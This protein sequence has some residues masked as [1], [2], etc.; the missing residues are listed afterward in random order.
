M[1]SFVLEVHGLCKKY[2]HQLVLNHFDMRVQ[3]GSIYGFVGENGAGKTTLIR[4]IAGLDFPTC[5]KLSL[6]DE[7]DPRILRRQRSRMGFLIEGPALYLDMTARQNLEMICIQRGIPD[8]Q[9]IDHILELMSLKEN[10]NKKVHNFSLGMRQRLGI[11]IALLGEPEFLIL[12]EPINGL[13]PTGILEIRDILIGL[14]K[15]KGTT[16]LI[17]SHILPELENMATHY[18]FI[19]KGRML[20]EITAE[21]LAKKCRQFVLLKTDNKEKAAAILEDELH[22]HEFDVYP[23]G[24]IHIFDLINR[25]EEVAACLTTHQ[26]AVKEI[27][28]CGERLENYFKNLIGV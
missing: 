2:G 9:E 1:N 7:S 10:S 13:D 20:Q 4:L 16:I 21:N 18:G 5:G 22:S 25:S 17:S 11:A 27:T 8:K 26:I 19:H 3:Q 14:N 15:R 23:D 12:D 24:S 28:I 6:F